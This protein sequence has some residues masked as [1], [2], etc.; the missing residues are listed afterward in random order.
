MQSH[1]KLQ[2]LAKFRS[3]FP[4]PA[5][6]ANVCCFL[7]QDPQIITQT[8]LLLILDRMVLHHLFM[9]SR[10]CDSSMAKMQNRALGSVKVFSS[11]CWIGITWERQVTTFPTANASISG[12]H[13]LKLVMAF[14]SFNAPNIE[15]IRWWLRQLIDRRVKTLCDL[16]SYYNALPVN[17]VTSV[18][19]IHNGFCV[20]LGHEI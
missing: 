4:A 9:I 3:P 11:P 8:K 20:C 1:S 19:V 15:S 6:T 17:D 14:P 2:I 10:C 7:V 18:V 5:I 12:P 16:P 13:S